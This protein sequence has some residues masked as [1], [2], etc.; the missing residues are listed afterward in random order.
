MAASPIITVNLW[1]DR[2]VLDQPFI[3]LPG[4]AMQWVFDKRT[5]FGDSASHLSLVSSGAAALCDQT[6]TAL[7]ALAHDELRQALPAAAS[8]GLMR[9]TVIREPRATFS[10]AVGQPERPDLQT[11]VQGLFLAGD[12]I[13]TGLPATIESAVRSGH[14]AADAAATS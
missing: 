3:R 6:N 12:W 5:V 13:A 8:A 4:R 9:A 11:G 2:P 1:F 14:R 7:I 10:L